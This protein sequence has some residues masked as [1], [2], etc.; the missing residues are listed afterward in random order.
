M[1]H[2]Q[3]SLKKKLGST[4]A[5]I[6]VVKMTIKLQVSLFLFLP[7]FLL[8]FPWNVTERCSVVD[9]SSFR[10]SSV[11]PPRST[12]GTQV[13]V[14]HPEAVGVLRTTL[15][16]F[17]LTRNPPVLATLS[18]FI[19]YLN[20]QGTFI[21]SQCVFGFV[22]SSSA[23]SDSAFRAFFFF[24]GLFAMETTAETLGGA[25]IPYYTVQVE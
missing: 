14:N 7:L 24:A 6:I 16:R 23:V 22:A 8:R 15:A 9:R 25:R 11:F 17:F 13:F 20:R 1:T 4:S 18:E 12:N 3:A 10:P 21:F 19:G 5:A 2:T